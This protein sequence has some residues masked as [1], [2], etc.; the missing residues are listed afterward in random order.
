MPQ[1][2]LPEHVRALQRPDA[3]EPPV[4]KVDLIQTHISFVLLAGEDVYKIKKPVD[5]GFL[6]FSTL[7]KRHAAC[8]AEVRLNRRGCPDIYFGVE[9]IT[10]GADHFA[11]GG[12]GEIVDYAVHMKRLRTERMMDRLLEQ[13]AIDFDMIGRLAARLADFHRAAETGLEIARI[14]G[15]E[16]L[17]QNWRDNLDDMRRFVGRTLGPKRFQRIEGYVTDFLRDEEP[18]LRRRE[19][20]GW[21]RD[22]HGDL[23]SDA[24]CFD[25][26]LDTKICLV[27]CIEFNDRMRY[28]DIGLDVGFL[29][30]DLDY[31]GR[32]DLSDLLLSLYSAA[33]GDKELPLL[34]NFYKCYRACVRGKV[35]SLLLDQAEV[36]REQRAGA[37]RRARVYFAL[38][39]QYARGL[40]YDG[41]VIVMGASGSGKSVLAGAI[42]TRIGAVL[43]ATDVIRRELFGRRE[44]ARGADEIDAGRYAPDARER[45]YTLLAEQAQRYLDEGSGV[46]LDG[47]YIERAQRETAYRLRSKSSQ[48]PL[49]VECY[50]PDDVVRQRQARRENEEWTASEGR[51]EVYQA[52]MRR[53]EAPDELP[54]RQRLTLDTTQPLEEQLEVVVKALPRR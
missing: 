35:E 5:F 51:W 36:G 37:R 25:D 52:Q 20:E 18:I 40:R 23:R 21:V 7:E 14:G 11:I 42:A 44:G 1:P 32:G 54:P 3:Y 24:V 38:A 13:G 10:R 50:A 6:D 16:T 53:Y 15:Y 19:A 12:N 47:T 22:C 29:A 9:P 4:D 34:I 43:L 27:D 33:M 31:R 48:P 2:Q 17:R 8:E 39:E 49:L 30:M 28:S 45:V 26:Q 46:V 41:P